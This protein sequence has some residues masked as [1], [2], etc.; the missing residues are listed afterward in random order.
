MSTQLNSVQRVHLRKPPTQ[1][2][3]KNYQARVAVPCALRA[4][5][6]PVLISHSEKPP[7]RGITG[8]VKVGSLPLAV[9]NKSAL[10][11]ALLQFCLTNLNRK[12]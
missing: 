7:D 10:T 6:M 12:T 1:G 11:R 3:G 4:R 8:R 5:T 9:R 2:Q